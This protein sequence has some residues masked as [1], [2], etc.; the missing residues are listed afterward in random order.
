MAKKRK[1]RDADRD[2][3]DGGASEYDPLGDLISRHQISL[4]GVL[5]VSTLAALV[6]LG[7]LTL[8]LL[9]DPISLLFVLI[10]GGVMLLAGALL[11]TSLF[12][13]GRRLELRK[14]GIRFTDRFYDVEMFWEEIAGI[15]VN[16]TDETDY[17][18]ASVRK[19]GG[20]YMTPSGPLTQTE[21]DVT[22]ESHDGRA[23]HLTSPFLNAVSDPRKLISQIR[24]RA[25]Q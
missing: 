17:G 25:G 14:K 20:H 9:R 15:H 16:R 24:L 2:S 5:I 8:G 18:M 13:I 12:N 23:I 6:G 7:L 3:P 21:W 22:I 19:R 11:V 4:V 1:R 10:G